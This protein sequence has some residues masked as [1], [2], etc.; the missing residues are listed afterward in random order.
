MYYVKRKE[1]VII[2]VYNS[3]IPIYCS[4]SFEIVVMAETSDLSHFLIDLEDEEC[5]Q[6]CLH[7]S[8]Y[9]GEAEKLEEML[10][11]PSLRVL[12]NTRIR[13]FLA[14]PL[15]L[16]ATGRSIVCRFSFRH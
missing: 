13:P 5:P 10:D 9:Q 15:R 16:A 3:S 11:D 6:F 4:S 2:R 1:N 7:L 12:V 8:A 14:T